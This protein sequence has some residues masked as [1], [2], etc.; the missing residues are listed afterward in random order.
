MPAVALTDTSNIHGC[1]EFFKECKK[2]DITPIMGTEIYVQSS[3][4]PNLNHKLVMLAKNLE[5]YQN[6]IALTSKAS[7][8]NAG[9]RSKITMEDVKQYSEHTMALSGP[10]T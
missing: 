6:I 1:H 3:L 7:L 5:G 2:Q 10:I 4:D 8:E 9:Q